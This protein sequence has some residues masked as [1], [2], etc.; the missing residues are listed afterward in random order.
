MNLKESHDDVILT[1]ELKEAHSSSVTC[2]TQVSAE[3]IKS[4]N[5]SPG[6]R[7]SLHQEMLM[8]PEVEMNPRKR[9]EISPAESIKDTSARVVQ[10]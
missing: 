2:S 3:I 1:Q 10:K 5:D 8:S 9:D 4:I 7:S 6:N